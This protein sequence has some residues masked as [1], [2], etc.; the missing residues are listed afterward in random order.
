MTP[1]KLRIATLRKNLGWTQSELA[2][3]SGVPQSTIWRLEKGS[4]NIDLAYLGKIADALGVN[5]TALID[6]VP[7]PK[8]EPKPKKKRGKQ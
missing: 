7:E 5:A 8:V 2:R 6:H 3:Q 1:V 4:T